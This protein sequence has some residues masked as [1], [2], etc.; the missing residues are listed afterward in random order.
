MYVNYKIFFTTNKGKYESTK[1]MKKD[2]LS[3]QTVNYA[4]QTKD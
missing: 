4:W 1:A 2:N 3:G